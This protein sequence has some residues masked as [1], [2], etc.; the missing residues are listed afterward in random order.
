M[1]QSTDRIGD[2]GIADPSWKLL[3]KTGAAAA[4]IA[5]LFFRRN[6]AAELV[7]FR[8]F[9]IVDVPATHPSSA[10]GWFEL[11]QENRLVALGLFEVKDIVNYALVGLVFLALYGALRWTNKSAMV[12]ATT[13]SFVGIA[14]YF[15]S[16]QA[17]SMASLSNQYAAATTDAQRSMFLAAG[18]ALL[19]I[20][21]PGVIYQGTGIYLSLFLV[22]LA[23]MII[24]FVMLQSSV[25]SKA[26]AYVGILANGLA[27][28]RFIVLAFAPALYGVPTVISAPFRV[29]WMI[30]IAVG[31]LRL[32]RGKSDAKGTRDDR[33]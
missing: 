13:F 8:G 11:L 26:T 28:G 32:G 7:A 17:F 20:N 30:L 29:L 16:N 33:L 1:S 12:I 4:L 21:N 5:V 3:Y 24:S 6:F 23:G 25:F 15:A 10:V 9:G 2:P 27:L 14:V 19:A 31:L 22:L 18:E